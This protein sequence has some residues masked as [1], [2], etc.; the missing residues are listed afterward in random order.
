MTVLAA[1]LV[2]SCGDSDGPTKPKEAALEKVYGDRQR[3]LVGA[4]LA[5]SMVVAVA[6]EGLG[7]P[8]ETVL[9]TVRTGDATVTP[10]RVAAIAAVGIEVGAWT[11]NEPAQ[12][13]DMLN[14]GVTRLY[15]DAPRRLLA[16]LGREGGMAD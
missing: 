12:M 5:D 2:T 13:R 11:V 6:L 4:V 14:A 7:M 9:F 3:G 1:A 15:T 16:L 8:G 10:D